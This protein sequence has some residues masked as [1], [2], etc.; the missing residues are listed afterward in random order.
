MIRI[1]WPI[2][3]LTKFEDIRKNDLYQHVQYKEGHHIA[4][5]IILWMDALGTFQGELHFLNNIM[6]YFLLH[7]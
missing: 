7:W 2:S 5:I 4:K 3:L 1:K 6:S